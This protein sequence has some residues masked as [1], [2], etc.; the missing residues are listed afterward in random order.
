MTGQPPSPA[1]RHEAQQPAAD[2]F[3]VLFQLDAT[4]LGG[5]IYCFTQ[6]AYE[7]AP[8]SFATLTYT[9]VD[10]HAEGFEW[11][12]AGTLPTP[13]IRMSNADRL[14]GSIAVEYGDL[15]GAKLTRI[16][17]FRRFLDGQPEADPFAHFPLDIY[18]IERK[19]TQNKVFV[20]WE[21]SAAMD[22]EGRML[23]GRQVLRD[24]CTHRYRR[25]TGTGWDSRDATCPYEG[26]LYFKADG[27]PTGAAAEDACGKRLSDCRKRFGS[28]G[29]LPTRAF[30]GVARLRLNR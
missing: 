24:A 30:P 19:T 25:W 10:I 8:V 5:G 21:L 29:V 6:S 26:G 12:S 15:L 9:P 11:N 20:E 17:T 1:L 22:Q 23:P 2:A 7:Q 3:V 13:R 28:T 4:A 16:R 18:R 27:T 14:V